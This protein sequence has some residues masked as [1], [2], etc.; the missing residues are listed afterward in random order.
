MATE[1][2]DLIASH[3]SPERPIR[4]SE[5]LRGRSQDLEKVE[6][7]LRHFHSVPFIYGY[8]GVGKTSLARTAAQLVTTSDR[9]HIYV[10]CAPGARMLQIFRE[11]GEQVLK[12]LFRSGVTQM[13]LKSVEVSLSLSP[14]IRASFESQKPELEDFRDANAAVRVLKELD[15]LLPDAKSTVVV[16]DELEELDKKD[17]SDLA[18]LIKQIGDQEFK[19]KFVLVGV[20]ENVHE[21]IGAHESVPRY[22]KE[23]SLKPLSPQDLIDIVTDAASAIG[24]KVPQDILYRIAIIGNGF[25]HFSHL[26]GKAILVE[27]VVAGKAEVDLVVYKAGIRSAV[28]DSYEELRTSYEAAT[29]RGEDYFKHLIWALA[30]SDVVD[31]RVNDWMRLHAELADRQHWTIPTWKKLKTAVGNFKS[32]NYGNIVTSTPARYGT[33]LTRYRYKRFSSSLMRGHVRLQAENEGVVLGRQ[34]GL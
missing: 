11:I 34:T 3:L 2:F 13:A 19:L 22:L 14:A 25:P 20:A 17:R 1:K 4:S 15:G 16:L 18:Y 23:V 33:F 26:I 27:A 31:V 8:R 29:Q 10:A 32:E 9:E 6:R 30:H 21:L 5:F 7:E 24:V 12:I 28:S